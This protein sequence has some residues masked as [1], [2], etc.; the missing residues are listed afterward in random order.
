[1]NR[2]PVRSSHLKSVGYDSTAQTLEVEFSD[3]DIYHYYN[4]PTHIHAGLMS[5]FSKGTFLNQRI[6]EAGYRYKKIR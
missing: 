5:A 6:K 2:T 3:G 1:M 4:V